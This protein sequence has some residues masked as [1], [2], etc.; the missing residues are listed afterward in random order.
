MLASRH[1]YS[2]EGR[3]AFSMQLQL[4]RAVLAEHETERLAVTKRDM[5]KMRSLNVVYRWSSQ[6]I[7]HVLDRTI[8]RD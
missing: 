4:V 3:S 8:F 2:L 6:A 7:R 5:L 1:S